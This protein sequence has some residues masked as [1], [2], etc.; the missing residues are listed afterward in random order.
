M[1]KESSSVR[2]NKC[3]HTIASAKFKENAFLISSRSSKSGTQLSAA[4]STSVFFFDDVSSGFARSS[5]G[6]FSRKTESLLVCALI[7][8][9]MRRPLCFLLFGI[10]PSLMSSFRQ[11]ADENETD[12]PALRECSLTRQRYF[13]THVQALASRDVLVPFE[14]GA[15]QTQSQRR[16]LR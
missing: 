4:I 6:Y 14:A 3:S 11:L 15:W 9:F 5:N 12:F 1:S 8:F 2:E 7:I 16:D 13:C 10:I